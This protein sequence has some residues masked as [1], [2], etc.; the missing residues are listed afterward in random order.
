MAI[1]LFVTIAVRLPTVETAILKTAPPNVP[2]VRKAW[3]R[4][5]IQSVELP[6]VCLD[7]PLFLLKA[8][9]PVANAKMV[10]F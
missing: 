8:L 10:F 1:D 4:F 7:R 3:E 6:I 2:F 9:L 5:Q